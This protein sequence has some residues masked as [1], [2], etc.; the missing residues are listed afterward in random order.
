MKK[1][2][3]LELVDSMRRTNLED[4]QR[5]HTA[6]MESLQ[7]AVTNAAPGTDV[8]VITEAGHLM[9]ATVLDVEHNYGVIDVGNGFAQGPREVVI[10]LAP[11]PGLD[12]W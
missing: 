7:Q 9:R 12:A 11:R 10:R 5:R 2:D 3:L 8:T 1:K 4:M 6:T